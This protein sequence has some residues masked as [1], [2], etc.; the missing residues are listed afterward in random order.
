MREGFA[1][2]TAA[3]GQNGNAVPM[4]TPSADVSESVASSSR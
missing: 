4:S 2:I 3:A 1:P